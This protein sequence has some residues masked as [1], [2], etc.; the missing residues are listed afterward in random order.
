MK[1][2]IA[3]F[4]IIL[5]STVAFLSACNRPWKSSSSPSP[6]LL[7]KA[8]SET[9][10]N[11]PTATQT[12]EIKPT[13]GMAS[14]TP[15]PKPTDTSEPTLTNTATATPEDTVEPTSTS[16]P[17]P[18]VEPTQEP[19]ATPEP[20]ATFKPPATPVPQ[21]EPVYSIT[22]TIQT[23]ENLYRIGLLYDLSWEEIAAA[24]GI[25][26]PNSVYIGLVLIIPRDSL[27]PAPT[28]AFT[29]IVQAG[30]N[31][32][33][34]GLMYGISWQEIADAN[35]ITNPND[36]YVGMSLTIPGIEPKE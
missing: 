5:I 30:E 10:T 12:Q 28:E 18:T 13:Q 31:L 33:R 2:S 23:G 11:T 34:I 6:T 3:T 20:T 9:A 36:I 25:T 24:N 7:P 8:G 21:P 16:T 22:H 32:Y 15:T 4:L 26:D 14:N 1:K 19:T 35:G 17:E 27:E 29:H